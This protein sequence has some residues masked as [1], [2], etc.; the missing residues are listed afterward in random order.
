MSD[1]TG[2]KAVGLRASKNGITSRQ[3]CK[4]SAV[5]IPSLSTKSIFLNLEENVIRAIMCIIYTD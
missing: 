4:N 2:A 3:H 5:G 1:L